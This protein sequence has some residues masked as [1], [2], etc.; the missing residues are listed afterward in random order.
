M[1]FLNM[2]KNE[3]RSL[4]YPSKEDL[5]KSTIVVIGSAIILSLL[6]TADTNAVTTLIG[7]IINKF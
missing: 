1:K 7:F 2:I 6:I 5:K 4:T 3:I